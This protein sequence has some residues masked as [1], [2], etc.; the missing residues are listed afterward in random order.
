MHPPE[1][2]FGKPPRRQQSDQ[3]GV[4]SRPL[5][6]GHLKPNRNRHP[7]APSA[8]PAAEAA[9]ASKPRVPTT[10]PAPTRASERSKAPEE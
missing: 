1:R 5:L 9:A 6:Q 8:G 2:G 10:R 3:A 7:Q 4:G